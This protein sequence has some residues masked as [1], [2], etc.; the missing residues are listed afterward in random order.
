MDKPIEY[1]LPVLET[2]DAI[3]K[4]LVEKED[5]PLVEANSVISDMLLFM[6]NNLYQKNVKQ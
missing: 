1:P 6:L 5:Q 2:Y 4:L 3:E